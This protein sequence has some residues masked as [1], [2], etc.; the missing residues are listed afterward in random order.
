M[1]RAK[2]DAAI[3]DLRKLHATW[4][5]TRV[6]DRVKAQ[7]A[8]VTRVSEDPELFPSILDAAAGNLARIEGVSEAKLSQQG[9]SSVPQNQLPMEYAERLRNGEN[10]IKIYREHRHLTQ[11]DL[12]ARMGVSQP[13]VGRLESTDPPDCKLST[14]RRVAESLDVEFAELIPQKPGPHR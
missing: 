7:T 3:A 2:L 14:L 6:A 12:A 9:G 1:N 4:T 10:P 8:F 11:K 5:S 13:L